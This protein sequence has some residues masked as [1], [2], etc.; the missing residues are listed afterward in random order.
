MVW[1]SLKTL[2]KCLATLLANAG[3]AAEELSEERTEAAL[4]PL[5]A[6][7]RYLLVEEALDRVTAHQCLQSGRT[8]CRLRHSHN[9][10]AEQLV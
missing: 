9:Q 8:V 3:R 7:V 4:Y 10:F 6:R 1:I 5:Q 2:K